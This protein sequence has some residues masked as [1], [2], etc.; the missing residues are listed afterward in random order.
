MNTENKLHVEENEKHLL[1][2][3]A[4]D[5]I[6]EL[7]H[8]LPS[9]WQATFYGGIIF[10]VIY[11]VYY[12]FMGG[13]TLRDEFKAHYSVVAAQQAE[14]KKQQ[15]IFNQE[16]YAFHNTEEGIAKGLQ[17]FQDNCVACHLDN[18]IGDI[19]PNL[20]DEYWLNSRGTP[21][22][23]YPVIFDG[24]IENGMPNW[25]EVLSVEEIY[26]V[27]AY[28]QTLHHKKLPGKEPQGEKILDE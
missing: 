17:I 14:Y 6:Q 18:G 13:P 5:G 9:W 8:P 19:G 21:E 26:Q 10:A 22:T 2:D 3:H 27:L 1:L 28:V 15:G 25:A 20:T 16:V 7:D 24:V 11:F 23:N 4:Y 12:Q